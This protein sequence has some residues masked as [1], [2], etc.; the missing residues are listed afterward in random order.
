MATWR[1]SLSH[2]FQLE[3]E[4][5][6]GIFYGILAAFF[7]G[8]MIFS[9]QFG[10]TQLPNTELLFFRSLIGL[11]LIL[12]HTL[13][14]LPDLLKPKALPL[15]VRGLISGFSVRVLFFNSATIGSANTTLIF[16]AFI[17]FLVILSA[18]VYK[19]RIRGSEWACIALVLSGSLLLCLPQQASAMGN[20]VTAAVPMWQLGLGLLGAFAAASSFLMIR[21]LSRVYS[22]QT[23]LVVY[24]LVLL[25]ASLLPPQQG[26]WQWPDPSVWGSLAVIGG[27]SALNQLY[28]TE[29]YARC[30]ASVA[31]L[32]SLTGVLWALFFEAVILRS[33]PSPMEWLAI[34]AMLFGLILL[35]TNRAKPGEAKTA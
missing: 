16:D 7:F 11:A 35:K 2:P 15:W 31:G 25:V 23:V 28:L 24:A 29:C 12:P 14:V 26:A 8:A 32:L 6:T 20:T 1:L 4:H 9:V 5:T 10:A 27:A 13:R 33:M 19:E 18:L 21:G 3:N 22:N 34:A 30:K 17:V